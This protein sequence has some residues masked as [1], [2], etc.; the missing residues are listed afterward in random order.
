MM[1]CLSHCEAATSFIEHMRENSNKSRIQKFPLNGWGDVRVYSWFEAD[2]CKLASIPLLQLRMNWRKLSV[3]QGRAN[4]AKSGFVLKK[5]SKVML[6]FSLSGSRV[7]QVWRKVSMLLMCG[8][9][10]DYWHIKHKGGAYSMELPR[11]WNFPEQQLLK[12]LYF[13]SILIYT[14]KRIIFVSLC[15]CAPGLDI[16]GVSSPFWEFEVTLEMSWWGY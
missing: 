8:I 6:N 14:Y 5:T 7:G 9:F 10:P 4:I 13:V 1:E 3:R 16:S 2:W 11:T 12:L 15:I